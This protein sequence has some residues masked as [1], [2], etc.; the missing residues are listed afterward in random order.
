MT[1]L[2]PGPLMYTPLIV[3][4]LMNFSEVNS[5]GGGG[6]GGHRYASDPNYLKTKTS[7]YTGNTVKNTQPLSTVKSHHH[8]KNSIR[9]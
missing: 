7:E 9:D 1:I 5:V 2:T 8:K 4:P 6:E 3:K